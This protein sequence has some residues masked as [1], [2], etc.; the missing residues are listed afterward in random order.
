MR[1][2]FLGTSSATPTPRRFLPSVAL[3]RG[4]EMFLFDCGEGTQ[5]R[6]RRAGLKFSRLSRILISHMHGDHVTGL[7]GLLMSLQMAER[8]EPLAIAGPVGLR[9]YVLANKRLMRTDFGYEL[10]FTELTADQHLV[11]DTPEYQIEA[12]RLDHRLPTYGYA[13]AEKDRPGRFDLDAARELGIPAGPL[14][15]RLQRGETLTLEDGRRITPDQVLGPPRPGLRCAYVTDTRPCANGRL[16]ARNAELLI[17]ESTFG[18]E[19]ATEARLKKHSTATEAAQI[20][21]A[22]GARRLVLTHFS[23]RYVDLE[24][25]RAEAAAIFPATELAVDLREFLLDN[26]PDIATEQDDDPATQ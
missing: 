7:M 4:G 3:V 18:G 10:T 14:F 5:I 19:L 12:A 20:A 15:G 23:P 26:E 2:V 13:L 16:L 25:L 22:A 6:F 17:H 11:C 1:L 24:P 9:D 8:T 21:A